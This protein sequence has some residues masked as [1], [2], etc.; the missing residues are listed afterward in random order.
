MKKKLKYLSFL[1]KNIQQTFFLDKL[2][3]SNIE[4]FYIKARLLINEKLVLSN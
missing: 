1:S 4:S 2:N 3:H